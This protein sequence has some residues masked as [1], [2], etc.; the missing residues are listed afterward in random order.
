[1]LKIKTLIQIIVVSSLF[2]INAGCSS[3]EEVSHETMTK[4]VSYDELYLLER[5]Q[6]ELVDK[7]SKENQDKQ[8]IKEIQEG[9]V[10]IRFNLDFMKDHPQYDVFEIKFPFTTY[11]VDGS[12]IEF[13]SDEGEIIRVHSKEM[14]WEE[15]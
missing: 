15:Y 2:I 7:L 3:Y 1:M 14:G 6:R 11:K 13:M 9:A 8:I 12:T 5:K 4:T 10:Q